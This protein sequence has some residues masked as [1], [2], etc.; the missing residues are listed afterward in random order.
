MS[1]FGGG[2]G[3]GG[4]GKLQATV[5]G[6]EAGSRGPR[7]IL[8]LLVMPGQGGKGVTEFGLSCKKNMTSLT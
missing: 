5:R 8:P 7:E 6:V 3:R 4:T 2:R 1:G